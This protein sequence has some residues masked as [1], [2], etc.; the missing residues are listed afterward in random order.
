MT[1]MRVEQETVIRWNEGDGKVIIYTASPKTAR[2][3][4]RTGIMQPDKARVPIQ[5]EIEAKRFR[6]GL[7]KKSGLS[8]EQRAAAGERLKKA[9]EARIKNLEALDEV[10]R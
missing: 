2:K 3:L 4:V 5:V 7:K 8:D 9:R 6:W 10:N 1:R